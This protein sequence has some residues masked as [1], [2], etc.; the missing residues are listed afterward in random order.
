MR[1]RSI[2]SVAPMTPHTFAST[3]GFRQNA[4]PPSLLAGTLNSGFMVLGTSCLPSIRP[5]QF[6][7]RARF[8]SGSSEP[9]GPMA[10]SRELV[11]KAD[12]ELPLT[13]PALL[14][15]FKARSFF[16]SS[17]GPRGH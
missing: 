17:Y 12:T 6:E 11:K 1:S 5:S 16:F 9:G 4:L 7:V 3:S 15:L 13:S 10:S 8:L 2:G 14:F